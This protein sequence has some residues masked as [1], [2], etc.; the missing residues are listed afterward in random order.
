[1]SPANFIN[2]SRTLLRR[3]LTEI[4]CPPRRTS[5]EAGHKLRRRDQIPARISP[6]DMKAKLTGKEN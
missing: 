5:L 4:Y 6:V 2:L 1:M 3:T